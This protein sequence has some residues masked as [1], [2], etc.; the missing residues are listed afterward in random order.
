MKNAHLIR[1]NSDYYDDRSARGDGLF[2]H[3]EFF[4][5]IYLL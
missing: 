1:N 5:H 2:V 4:S 3:P